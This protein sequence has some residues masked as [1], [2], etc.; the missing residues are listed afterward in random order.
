MGDVTPTASC[1]VSVIFETAMIPEANSLRVLLRDWS[2]DTL[3]FLRDSVPKIVL[4]LVGAFVLIR[5]LRLVTRKVISIQAGRLTP[6]NR[7]QEVRTLISVVTN[8][9]I[10]VILFVA[11]LEILP[12]L[13]LNVGP[14]TGLSRSRRASDWVRRAGIGARLHQ[15][16]LHFAR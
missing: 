11:A 5:L 13:G 16:I 9:G 6:E 1:T 7:A 15:R 14:A 4:V 12:M 10:S 3:R 2:Q 8:I